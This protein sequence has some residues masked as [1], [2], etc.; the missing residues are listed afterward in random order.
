[1]P[2]CASLR[3]VLTAPEF[4]IWLHWKCTGHQQGDKKKAPIGE[5]RQGATASALRDSQTRSSRPPVKG[6]DA[7]RARFSKGLGLLGTCT[8]KKIL[9]RPRC[10]QF[11][12]NRGT[13]DF[14]YAHTH[15]IDGRTHARTIPRA[16]TEI[17]QRSTQLTP[18]PLTPPPPRPPRA[19]TSPT[20]L[21]TRC[22]PRH[23]AQTKLS[24]GA[25]QQ[26]NT[27]RLRDTLTRA[28]YIR[29]TTAGS[30]EHENSKVP[31]LSRNFAAL[32]FVSYGIVL[33]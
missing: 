29:R 12:F 21:S 4:P 10:L 6:T 18:Q 2:P 16:S 22:C 5:S 33:L 15:K 26:A 17:D 20:R 27:G 11:A 31:G 13:K 19:C 9:A 23:K 32:A 7:Y 30:T 3:E 8:A 25:T 24:P 1:M 28:M 14:E